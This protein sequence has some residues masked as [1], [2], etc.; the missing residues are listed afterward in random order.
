MKRVVIAAMLVA[1][2]AIPSA[3]DELTD[4]CADLIAETGPKTS[5]DELAAQMTR[6]VA[7]RGLSASEAWGVLG[8]ACSVARRVE[9]AIYCFAQ[10]AQIEPDCAMHVSNLGFVL[11]TRRWRW[12]PH[13]SSCPIRCRCR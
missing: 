12:R 7:E 4:L 13:T 9:P 11:T 6:A 10:A 3:A 8:A 5:P 1:A 2:L